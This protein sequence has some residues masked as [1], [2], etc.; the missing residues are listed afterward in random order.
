M[1]Q[2]PNTTKNQT[3]ATNETAPS[4]R[5]MELVVRE[6]QSNSGEIA[7]ND[8]MKRLIQSNFI[9]LDS[10]L[11][12]AEI[13]RL[14]KPEQSR[15]PLELAWKNVNMEKMAQDCISF[16]MVGLD[17]MLPNQLFLIPYKNNHTN[18]YDIGFMPGYR[19]IEI[20][21]KKY[22]INV[23]KSEVIELVYS[24]DHFEVLKKDFNNPVESYK[25]EIKN[26][27]DRG[28]IIGG[29]YYF[30]YEDP[31]EN[32]IRIFSI[33]E[34]LKRKPKYASPEFWGG[35]KDEWK[36][37]KV[38]GKVK[39]DGWY[40]E[41]CYKTLCRAAYGSITLDSEK[42]NEHLLKSLSIESEYTTTAATIKTEDTTFTDVT[43]KKATLRDKI[44][45][46]ENLASQIP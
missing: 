10:V 13:K 32:E 4:T 35:E 37:G 22:G 40:H 1:S 5:F 2:T 27:F 25:F 7:L 36:G 9:K 11:K 34:I 23:P 3:P 17:P 24:N 15:E 21:A 31:T 16:S 30:G 45:A 42:I 44:E 38:V 19:G 33:D 6:F 46:G 26:P 39:V 29:F 18:K 41:M 12:E 8:Q 43:D 20:R 28:E 14:A